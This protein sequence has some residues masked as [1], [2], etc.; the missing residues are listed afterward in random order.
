MFNVEL[1]KSSSMDE[2]LDFILTKIHPM[3]EDL[4]ETEYWLDTRWLEIRDDLNFHETVL[5]IFREKGEYLVS[6]DGNISKGTWKR[7]E[8]NTLILEHGKKHELYDLAFLNDSF[9]VLKKHGDQARKGQAKYFVIGKEE[10][11]QELE[12]RDSMELLFNV[13]RSNNS[14]LTVLAVVVAIIA[15]IVVLSIM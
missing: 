3:S 2:Y 9:F 1:P 11:V 13:Y 5:H 12:W 10:E 15:I 4:D 8:G 6:I 7:L 14:W